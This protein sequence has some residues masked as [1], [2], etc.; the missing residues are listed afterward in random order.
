MRIFFL[1]SNVTKSVKSNSI[2]SGKEGRK[3]IT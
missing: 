2:I 3:C 1:N